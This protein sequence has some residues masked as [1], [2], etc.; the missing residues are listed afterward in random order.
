[1]ALV[2]AGGMM[3]PATVGNAAIA[4][5]PYVEAAILA[6][7]AWQESRP[8]RARL[9]TYGKKTKRFFNK[10]F[11]KKKKKKKT[12]APAARFAKLKA[13]RYK[14]AGSAR[15][16]GPLALATK[17]FRK[18]RRTQRVSKFVTA[19]KT[20]TQQITNQNIGT[21]W[22]GFQHHDSWDG[23]MRMAT[24][25]V[26]QAILATVGVYPTGQFE[27]LTN[28]ISGTRQGDTV[29]IDVRLTRVDT[30]DGGDMYHTESISLSAYQTFHAISERL[31]VLCGTKIK[32]GWSFYDFSV[33]FTNASEATLYRVLEVDLSNAQFMC[34]V[35][36]RI[37]MQNQSKAATTGTAGHEDVA[38]RLNIHSQ[39][40]NG[41]R[42]EF[43]HA[44]A[45]VHD[46]V[47]HGNPV[48][49]I[50]EDKTPESLG[51]KGIQ[52]ANTA[53]GLIGTPPKAR[54]V[55][56]NCTGEVV[57]NLGPGAVKKCYTSFKFKGTLKQYT[58]KIGGLNQQNAGRLD[59]G[60]ITYFAFTRAIKH[61]DT[62]ME[63]AFQRHLKSGSFC[64]LRSTKHQLKRVTIDD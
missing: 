43:R 38:N 29:G 20:Q 7:A 2:P 64:K 40:L 46:M 49:D 52:I 53:G 3:L 16:G 21:S 51:H 63:I 54:E 17:R 37:D 44:Q 45:D 33:V 50:F 15:T 26:V 22:I 41:K 48:M 10:M 5:Q 27:N 57:I 1:M 9:G 56:K 62:D 25:G 23:L 30:S 14:P 36:Q 6:D 24:D 34:Y 58:R 31:A 8:F 55:F 39:P 59:Y 19:E 47:H 61:G 32:D 13:K 12:S 4:A 60:G 42:Y 18:P 28:K 11:G 35:S